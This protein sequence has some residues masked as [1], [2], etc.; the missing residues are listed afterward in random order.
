M[1]KRRRLNEIVDSLAD[2]AVNMAADYAIDKTGDAIL[3]DKEESEECAKPRKRKRI[4]EED[5]ET[6]IPSATPTGNNGTNPTPAVPAANPIVAPNS[7]EDEKDKPDPMIEFI[8]Q[9]MQKNKDKQIQDAQ[10]DYA[11]RQQQANKIVAD[12]EDYIKKNSNKQ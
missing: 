7:S 9:Q 4:K 2:K 5:V 10:M 3:D 8:L 11:Y 12:I 6:T 1:S